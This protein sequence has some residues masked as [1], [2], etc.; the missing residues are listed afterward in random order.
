M[1]TNLTPQQLAKANTRQ[2]AKDSTA[3]SKNSPSTAHKNHHH[4]ITTVAPALNTAM[5]HAFTAALHQDT[6]PN[7]VKQ[8]AEDNTSRG[9]HGGGGALTGTLSLAPRAPVLA[10][11][12]K[13]VPVGV[14]GTAP[15]Q[16][17]AR[18]AATTNNTPPVPQAR[19]LRGKM[20]HGMPG[21]KIT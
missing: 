7:A 19:D 4:A 9:S 17:N 16:L 14:T 20:S 3:N 13:P 12:P 21:G 6:Q 5:A 10:S 18:P 1:S 8:R 15:A 2:P 11:L